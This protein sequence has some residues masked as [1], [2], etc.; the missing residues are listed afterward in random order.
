MEETFPDYQ[1]AL[2]SLPEEPNPVT[3]L[4]LKGRFFQLDDMDSEAAAEPPQNTSD[5]QLEA[6]PLSTHTTGDIPLSDQPS[7]P[8]IPTTAEE[9]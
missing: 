3:H 5:T 9:R 2:A 6:K 7:E 1:T 4:A 8:L